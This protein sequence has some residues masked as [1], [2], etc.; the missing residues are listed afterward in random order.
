MTVVSVADVKAH[1]N[2][3]ADDDD[4][5]IAAQIEAAEKRLESE[6]GKAFLTQTRIVSFDCW[7]RLLPLPVAPVQSVTEVRYLDP[8]YDE[9]T[10][11][12]ASYIVHPVDS[13][14]AARVYIKDG[15]SLPSLASMIGA[16]IT[17]E[18]VCG[19]GDAADVPA[20]LKE[21]VKRLA[22]SFY[23]QREGEAGIP[24]GVMELVAP[25]RSYVF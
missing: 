10:L 7:S 23:E 11:A 14:D 17:V 21:A 1:L 24:A 12:P 13:E 19:Y 2:I 16:A 8:D 3:L 25:Y 6:I 18:F 20:D 15:V 22:A 5:L 4:T 9:Q